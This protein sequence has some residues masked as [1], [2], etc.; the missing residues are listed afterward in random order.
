MEGCIEQPTRNVARA[1]RGHTHTRAHAV[2]ATPPPVPLAP[3]A[4]PIPATGTAEHERAHPKGS[5]V[6]SEDLPAIPAAPAPPAPPASLESPIDDVDGVEGDG[7]GD[8]K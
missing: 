6:P 2:L 7:E 1:R 4:S 5:P 8:G 3:P